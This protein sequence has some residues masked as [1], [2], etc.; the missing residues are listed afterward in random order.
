MC[1]L[2]TSFAC[3]DFVLPVRAR[4]WRVI[5]GVGRKG[6]MMRILNVFLVSML[7]FC[8]AETAHAEIAIVPSIDWLVVQADVICVGQ[9][10]SVETKFVSK[11]VWVEKVSLKVTESIQYCRTDE[12]I[13]FA[14]QISDAGLQSKKWLFSK[15]GLFVLLKRTDFSQRHLDASLTPVSMNRPLTLIDLSVDTHKG[16]YTRSFKKLT[17]GATIMSEFLGAR[18]RLIAFRRKTKVEKIGSSN[19]AVPGDTEMFKELWAD[20]SVSMT[21]PSYLKEEKE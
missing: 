2:S 10:Q 7:A 20:S 3:S 5:C 14:Y 12:T 13:S 17:K 21:I 19:I 1:P 4:F 6:E 18:D 16:F 15:K 9:V 8:F 11:G